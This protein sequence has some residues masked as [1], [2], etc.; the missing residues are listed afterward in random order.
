MR[1]KLFNQFLFLQKNHVI[2]YRQ[3]YKKVHYSKLVIFFKQ[4]EIGQYVSNKNCRYSQP[5]S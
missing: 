1:P 3:K 2:R 4:K 5:S